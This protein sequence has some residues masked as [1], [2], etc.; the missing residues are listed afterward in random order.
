MAATSVNF[1][2]VALNELGWSYTKLIAELRRE[3]APKNFGRMPRSRLTG[4][5]TRRQPDAAQVTVPES[6][7]PA[8]PVTPRGA[9]RLPR[10]TAP[11]LS[12][13]LGVASPGG[14]CQL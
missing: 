14:Q 4:T 8:L 7:T 2:A 3:A 12:G 1:L 6:A 9:V 13:E 5:T 11:A 10:Q